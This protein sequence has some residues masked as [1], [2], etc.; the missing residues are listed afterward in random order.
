MALET[1]DSYL[2]FENFCIDLF[3]K[4]EG[5]ELVP[6]SRSWDYGRDGRSVLLGR[7]AVKPILCATLRRDI[8]A[9]IESD[10]SRLHETTNTDS[11]IYCS[12]KELTEARCDS[13]E[14]RIREL[15]P[16]LLTI[17]VVGQ[18]QFINLVERHEE[19]FRKHYS[20]EIRNIER[21][22]L[23]SCVSQD[24]RELGLRL[25]LCT[26]VG[27]DAQQLRDEIA[28]RLFLH[29]LSSCD[30]LTVPQL[31]STLANQLHLPRTLSNYYVEEVVSHLSS[32]ELVTYD[33]GL[34]SITAKGRH[35]AD[36]I[37][38]ESQR[39]LLEGRSAVREAIFSLSGHQL[40]DSQYNRLWETFQ[41]SMT[42]LFYS[43]GLALVRMI[44]SILIEELTSAPKDDIYSR[45]IAL[46]E[47]S[48]S[49]FSSLEQGSEVKQA[50]IDMFYEKKNP[51]FEWL[52]QICGI[53]VMM[54]SLGLEELSN[55]QV[56]RV[57]ST[58]HV[59]PDSDI[60]ISL[61][62]E[63]EKNHEEVNRIMRGW[64]AVGGKIMLSAPV[65]EEV[66]YHAWISDYD[67]CHF[68]PNL[69]NI[70][71]DDANHTIENAFVRAFRKSARSETSPSHWYQYIQQYRGTSGKDY[72]KIL[73]I[74]RYEFPLELMPPAPAGEEYD[75]LSAK[76]KQYM[77]HRMSEFSNAP[78]SYLD[79]RTID[80]ITRDCA[81]VVS[82]VAERRDRKFQG[83]Y[84][85]SCIISSAGI[86]KE[87]DSIFGHE[88]DP[89]EL[90]LSTAAISFLLTLTPQVSMGFGTL[91]SVLFDSVLYQ[92]LTPA[93]R[94]AFRVITS[95]GQ[96][97]VP[98]SRR[99]ALEQTLNDILLREARSRGMRVSD[100]RA[101]VIGTKEPEYSATIIAE[102]LNRMAITPKERQELIR[103]KNELVQLQKELSRI[104]SQKIPATG[105]R[106]AKFRSK[107]A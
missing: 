92:R 3:N 99:G 14:N 43:H 23:S 50:I 83:D 105:R 28:K 90:I 53:Y 87:L 106:R 17:R 79:R 45:L 38:E 80:K 61:L 41:D 16:S 26:Q 94:H 32:E 86:L 19:I 101:R 78:V 31:A 77:L 29:T 24:V 58:Y 102:T 11:L 27:D 2:R 100:T 5:V 89:P 57:L 95:S 52:S 18:T 35:Y 96:W 73:R 69:S 65:L 71:D 1:D 98:W 13:L 91:R 9:K 51:A 97:N 49:H 55:Q 7:A 4:I 75:R 93:Q 6:T 72:A 39:K 82:V 62:C 12:S 25:A 104:K 22:L 21:T 34:I 54:C 70:S 64:V 47:K 67:Y 30:G 107:N 68:G 103:A 15:C 8:D 74:L 81:L 56:I 63:G 44:R 48:V 60:L 88:F 66:A 10:I 33:N 20:A 76:I 84:T 40:A 46:A 36:H 42:E 59:V 37:P 85:T